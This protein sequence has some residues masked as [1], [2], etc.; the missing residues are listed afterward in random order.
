MTDSIQEPE[1]L[2]VFD[3]TKEQIEMDVEC[4]YCAPKA[5]QCI[6]C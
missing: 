2:G 4:L 1:L 6:S 3:L 5:R